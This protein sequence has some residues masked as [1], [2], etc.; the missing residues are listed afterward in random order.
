[1]PGTE[2]T[3]RTLATNPKGIDNAF[4]EPEKSKE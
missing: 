2:A 1:M 4:P 3:P